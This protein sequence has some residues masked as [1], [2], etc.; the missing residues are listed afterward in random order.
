MH[1]GMC[2]TFK[3]EFVVASLS[4]SSRGQKLKRQGWE[5]MSFSQG[6]TTSKDTAYLPFVFSKQL[7]S[8]LLSFHALLL[9]SDENVS[10]VSTWSLRD[11]SG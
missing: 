7:F 5:K 10:L 3:V 11:I 4:I 2:L 6:I 1:S 9:Y 8:L